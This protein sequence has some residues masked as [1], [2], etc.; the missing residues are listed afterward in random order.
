M[1]EHPE[2]RKTLKEIALEAGVSVGTVH[3]AIYGKPG[4]R[5]DTRQR[6]LA[7]VEA[8]NY[9]VNEVASMMKRSD[10]R[11]AVVLPGPAREDRFFFR[12]IW[13]GVRAA[14]ESLSRYK[15]RFDFIESNHRIDKMAKA[16][17]EL[18]DAEDPA[19]INGL[20]T[21]ADTTEAEEWVTR[22][23]RRGV[24]VILVAS[25]EKQAQ[26]V[27][28]IR[29]DHRVCGRLAAEFLSYALHDRP[30]KMLLLPGQ[31]DSHSNQIYAGGF[32]ERLAELAPKYDLLRVEGIG[33]TA[34][35]A[36]VREVMAKERLAAIFSCNARNTFL[37]GD[38]VKEIPRDKKPLF[39]GTDV[40][41]EIAPYFDDGTLDASVYQF[42][43][44]QG[45]MAVTLLYEHLTGNSIEG[46]NQTAPALL[47][48]RSNYRMFMS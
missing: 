44:E 11:I 15:L 6:I 38:L 24:S 39:V 2:N 3:R 26:C 25:Y 7:I 9:K 45:E 12:G 22:F 18:Y 47:A 14:A 27:A 31:L 40:F 43:R 30:G 41:D 1:D 10:M 32:E 37:L 19:G 16:L 46:K 20:V 21:I 29:T 35:A 4:L 42:H 28:S 48:L 5:D 23:S 34:V 33:R 13:S 36:K 8:A 17:Q